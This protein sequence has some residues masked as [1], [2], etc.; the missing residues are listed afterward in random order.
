M[1]SLTQETEQGNKISTR[2]D[3]FSIGWDLDSNC[4]V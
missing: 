2:T 3:I 1:N 4:P